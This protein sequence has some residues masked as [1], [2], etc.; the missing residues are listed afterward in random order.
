MVD[1]LKILLARSQGIF[2]DVGVNTGQTLVK[3][4]S[5]EL[6]REYVGLEP[7]LFCVSY[8]QNLIHKNGFPC[9]SVLPAALLEEAG[10]LELYSFS[11]DKADSSASVISGFRAEDSISAK[12][13]VVA[14]GAGELT[15]FLSGKIVSIIKIDVEGAE[16]ECLTALDQFLQHHK[17]VLLVEILPVYSE[18]NLLRL[19]RQQA[20]EALLS[21]RGYVMYR[22]AKHRD[23]SLFK[24]I[25]IPSI[26]IHANL[27]ACDYVFAPS[28]VNLSSAG[29]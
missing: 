21:R 10:L 3:V 9:C 11:T 24:L 16:L 19:R 25:K 22:I 14:I 5:I 29:A 15:Q 1:L 8:V 17:P 26:G 23:D 7:N 18:D 13:T 20:I 6:H 4:K 2:L 12:S 28:E 27:K